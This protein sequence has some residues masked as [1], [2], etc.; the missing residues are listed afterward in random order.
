MIPT[1]EKNQ[2]YREILAGH[3]GLEWV[4]RLDHFLRERKEDIK[5]IIKASRCRERWLHGELFFL[6]PDLVQIDQTSL[7][8]TEHPHWK[9]KKPVPYAAKVD[10]SAPH[11]DEHSVP[12]VVAEIKLVSTM[13]STKVLSGDWSI[14]EDIKRLRKSTLPATTIHL[15][16]V[17]LVN[18]GKSNLGTKLITGN[19]DATEVYGIGP[20]EGDV[21]VRAWMVPPEGKAMKNTQ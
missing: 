21:V 11:P 18:E 1:S 12:T 7:Y 15:L 16:I 13:H 2:D 14:P 4:E 3:T 9:T 19:Q 6:D 8:I 17:V 20:E 5:K 10:F